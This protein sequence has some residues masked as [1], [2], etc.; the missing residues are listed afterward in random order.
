[1]NTPV[2]IRVRSTRSLNT[3]IP[4]PS[5][6]WDEAEDLWEE[7]L[8]EEGMFPEDVFPSD[9]SKETEEI[10]FTVPSV[11]TELTSLGLFSREEDGSFR[12]SYE[13]SSVTGLEGCL[14]TFCLSPSGML[15]MLRRGTVK[16]C[17]VFEK[18]H[19]H[20]CD[21]GAAAGATTVSLHTH[22]LEAD[23]TNDGG[24][25]QVEYTV[26][27]RGSITEKNRLCITVEKR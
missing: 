23:F 13:D 2:T 25:V 6:E 27:M 3:P 16:T 11:T 21:Y 26:E 19:R 14:T 7:I 12:L 9:D 8:S 17:L 4:V 20:L 1:M 22:L 5:A 10:P 15:I 24:E 18:N